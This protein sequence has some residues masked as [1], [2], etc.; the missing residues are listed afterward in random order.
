MN[1]L[2]GGTLRKRAC[3][4]NRS[5]E[6]LAEKE[7][8]MG[9][10]AVIEGVMMRS[11]D[12]W[13]VAVRSPNGEIVVKKESWLPAGKRFRFLKLP[14]LRGAVVLVETL[15][16]GVKA[17][18]FSADVA[19]SEQSSED[20]PAEPKTQKGFWWTVSLIGTVALSLLLGIL[21][22]FYIPLLLTELLNIESP[23]LFNLVDGLLR[24][25]FFLA[26]L[27]IISRWQEIK[28]VFEYHGAEHKTIFAYEDSKELTW[29]NIRPYSTFHQ[30]CGTS[31]ILVLML[32]SILVFILLGKPYLWQ[33]RLLRMLIIPLIGGITYELIKL[34]DRFAG[35]PVVRLFIG[36]GLWLQRI[37][38]RQPDK[39]QVE[40]AVAS[41]RAALGL[42]QPVPVPSAASPHQTAKRPGY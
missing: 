35:H 28:R 29:D 24:V 30:R 5:G 40:V 41:L 26:Y 2:A 1:H 22:F 32:V 27:L 11:A 13:A 34:G 23:I 16:L 39:S 3:V 7:I 31:F 20:D 38:T 37:T 36:P 6:S 8:K 9:G 21:I 15:V 33:D 17:L 4:K 25:V 18:S 14:V 12:T 10:Q 42:D 19:S